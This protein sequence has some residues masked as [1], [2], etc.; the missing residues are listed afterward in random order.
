MATRRAGQQARGRVGR[1][2]HRDDRPAGVERE[3]RTLD[4]GTIVLQAGEVV[5]GRADGSAVAGIH[6]DF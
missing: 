1:A 4:L 5:R 3:Q 6:S 2:R